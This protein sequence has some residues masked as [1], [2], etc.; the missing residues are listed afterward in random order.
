MSTRYGF[1]WFGS[2]R[3]TLNTRTIPSVLGRLLTRVIS[4]GRV[5][6]LLTRR[7]RNAVMHNVANVHVPCDRGQTS[8]N[9]E[10]SRSYFALRKRRFDGCSRPCA[11]FRYPDQ[12]HLCAHKLDGS[13]CYQGL[14]LFWGVLTKL[15]FAAEGGNMD[16][17]ISRRKRGKPAADYRK[18]WS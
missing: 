16:Q 8:S 4:K 1:V 9:V 2:C 5:S 18:V 7:G 13:L 14:T 6:R 17:G 11:P 15:L 3:R 10:K 12:N